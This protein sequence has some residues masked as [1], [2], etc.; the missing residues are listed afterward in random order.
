MKAEARAAGDLAL[1]IKGIMTPEDTAIAADLGV[2]GVMIS[3]HGGPSLPLLEIFWR[4]F[5]K[6][7]RCL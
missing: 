5:K 1:V 2:D 6:E 4:H 7:E 3:N